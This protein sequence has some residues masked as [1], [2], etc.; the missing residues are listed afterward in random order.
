MSLVNASDSVRRDPRHRHRA[1]RKFCHAIGADVVGRDHRLAAADQ[2]AQADVVAFG[3]F[4]FLHASI[5]HFDALRHA[6]HRDRVGS[7]RAGVAGGL[8]EALRQ[9]AQRG[10]IEQF[11]G[12]I[13]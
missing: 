4:G 9:R 8:D 3:A 1:L 10:K 6:A 13:G 5:T 7:V 2:H 11:G 12:G